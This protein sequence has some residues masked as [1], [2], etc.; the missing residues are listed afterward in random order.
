MKAGKKL[1]ISVSI[2][3][4]LS[5]SLSHSLLQPFW[6]QEGQEWWITS[7]WQGTKTTPKKQWKLAEQIAPRKDNC[8]NDEAVPWS[9]SDHVLGKLCSPQVMITTFP[10]PSKNKDWN[11]DHSCD[12]D[13][14]TM[15]PF[16]S[17]PL[18]LCLFKA[19]AHLCILKM[20]VDRLNAYFASSY[21]VSWTMC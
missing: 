15:H 21:G 11:N 7:L 17:L 9:R 20:A 3:Y 5:F 4:L 16:H 8:Y 2:L 6:N 13:C 19:K 18:V 12:R 10:E 14:L 1:G